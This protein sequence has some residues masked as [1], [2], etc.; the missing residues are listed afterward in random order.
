MY[1]AIR[2]LQTFASLVLI[3]ADDRRTKL[4]KNLDFERASCLYYA[5]KK[6]LREY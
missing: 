2:S 1:G 5:N 6:K 3:V 4:I